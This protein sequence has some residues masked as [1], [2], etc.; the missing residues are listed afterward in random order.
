MPWTECDLP[1]S[2]ITDQSRHASRLGADDAKDRAATQ[3]VRYLELLKIHGGGLTDA[4]A[5]KLMQIERTSI[6]ARRAPLVK[7][8]IVVADGYRSGPT[9]RVKNTVWRIA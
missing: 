2:G 6:N 8:G 1:F 3:Q 7:A 4:E 5:A 9:G